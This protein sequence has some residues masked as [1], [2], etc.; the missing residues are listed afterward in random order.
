MTIEPITQEEF[1]K[2]TVGVGGGWNASPETVAVLA[3]PVGQGIK[4]PCRWNHSERGNVCYGITGLHTAAKNH[5]M[6]GQFN[7][8]CMDKV[9]YVFHT[10]GGV[11]DGQGVS[12]R[13][14]R[15]RGK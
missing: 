12:T 2:V 8:R 5:G 15:V 9:L 10:R 4:F 3:L 6:V 7:F 14:T 1:A 13:N 11:S